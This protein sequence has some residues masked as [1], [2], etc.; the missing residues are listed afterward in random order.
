MQQLD[1]ISFDQ[2]NGV[3]FTVKYAGSS[4]R[5]FVEQSNQWLKQKEGSATTFPSLVQRYAKVIFAAATAKAALSGASNDPWGHL[6]TAEDLFNA[7]EA[8]RN[9]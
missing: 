7:Q 4:V 5:C 9:D 2:G 8:L 1:N 6:I 3:L